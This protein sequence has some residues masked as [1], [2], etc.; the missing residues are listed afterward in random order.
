MTKTSKSRRFLSAIDIITLA[1]CGW[2]LIYMLI[3]LPRVKDPGI[4]FPAY[5]SI[6]VGILLLA[7]LH[8]SLNSALHPKWDKALHLIRSLYPIALFGY[9]F[10]SGYSV[11]Q[12]IFTNWLD[13]FFMHIDQSIFGYLP[14]LEWGNNYAHPLLS[15]LFHFAYFCYY[16][17]IVGLPLY[18]YLKK[19]AAFEELIF[20]LSFVFYLCYFIYSILPVIGAR[21][22][23]EAMELTK[24]FRAG[25]FTHIMVFIYRN[26]PHLGGAF[27][28]SHI[29]I[30]LVLTVTALKHVR[31]LG[32]VFLVI[33]FFLSIATI[34]CHYHWFID[35][36]FGILTGIGGYFLANQVHRK[37]QGAV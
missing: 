9:F 10:T 35:A 20:N 23:P 15:E 1:Y 30:A 29:G 12:I 34:Y 26:S 17:M 5:L 3:G 2:I 37:L 33:S 13:P 7:W 19:P 27:P 6:T 14:S 4:H 8:K 16:P 18:L 36:V 32:Y 21:Y 22:I 24:T 28:S 11:N 31:R 25:P